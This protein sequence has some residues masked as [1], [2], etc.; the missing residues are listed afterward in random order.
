MCG[1]KAVAS[2]LDWSFEVCAYILVHCGGTAPLY[3]ATAVGM[4]TLFLALLKALS[5]RGVN[6]FALLG[7]PSAA[8]CPLCTCGKD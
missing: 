4:A 2:F 5:S 7:S 3:F 8:L 6:P 1:N